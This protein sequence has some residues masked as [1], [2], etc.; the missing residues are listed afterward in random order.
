MPDSSINDGWRRFLDRLRRLWGRL[1]PGE[2][3]S[4]PMVN[5]A[6]TGVPLAECR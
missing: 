2:F 4:R 6:G 5:M 3:A 1:G